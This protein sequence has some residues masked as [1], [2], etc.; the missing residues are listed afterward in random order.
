MTSE[1]LEKELLRINDL[2]A[3]STW[4]L[5]GILL[6]MQL[7]KDKSKQTLELINQLEALTNPV[8]KAQTRLA[9]LRT[10]VEND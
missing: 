2:L 5:K 4:A 10:Q 8:H 3:D 6:G 7:T 1:Q 9:T